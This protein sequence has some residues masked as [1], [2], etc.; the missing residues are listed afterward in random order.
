MWKFVALVVFVL[1]YFNADANAQ[2]PELSPRQLELYNKIVKLN[3]ELQQEQSIVEITN[4]IMDP[5]SSNYDKYL[6]YMFKAHTYKSV[7]NYSKTTTNLDLALEYGLKTPYAEILTNH[8]TAEKS[9][10]YFDTQDFDKAQEMIEKLRKSDYKHLNGGAKSWVLMQEGYI[11]MLNKNYLHA[12]NLLDSAEAI[13]LSSSP[14]DVTNIYGKKI[15]LYH[16]MGRFDQRDS[17]FHFAVEFAR[18]EKQIKY[19]MYLFEV[20]K[21]IFTESKDY[22][23][24]HFYQVK[25]D[26]L[27]AV[28]DALNRNEAIHDVEKSIED[29][30]HEKEKNKSLKEKY[31]LSALVLSFVLLS[32]I[33]LLLYRKNKAKRIK[34]EKENAIIRASVEQLSQKIENQENPSPD[35]TKYGFTERQIEVIQLVQQGKSNK[36]I[37]EVLFISENTVKYHLRVIYESLNIK[38]RIDLSKFK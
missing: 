26:S 1:I 8:V 7:F 15:Q 13:I 31:F 20:M 10:V 17:L 34:L 19:E 3:Q 25:F 30:E 37:A 29:L 33:S 38:K 35:Y 12:Q 22:E 18:I 28:F 2:L 4:F 32:V 23:K 6:G 16:E 11:A 14:K 27:N 9:F 21:N 24:A 5:K 36:E